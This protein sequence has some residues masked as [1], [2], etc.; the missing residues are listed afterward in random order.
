MAGSAIV[1]NLLA[2]GAAAQ[3]AESQICR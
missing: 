1:G 2:M 3:A